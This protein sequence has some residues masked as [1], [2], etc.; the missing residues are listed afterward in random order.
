MFS[1][2]SIVYCRLPPKLKTVQLIGTKNQF[3]NGY[4]IQWTSKF[5]SAA[6]A[7]K[8]LQYYSIVEPG[9]AAITRPDAMLRGKH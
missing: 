6:P 5:G 2:F 4:F 8:P 1:A 7:V 9:Q 3:P